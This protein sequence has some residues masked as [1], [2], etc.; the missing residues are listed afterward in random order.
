[1]VLDIGSGFLQAVK[2]KVYTSSIMR[3]GLY[4][5]CG[6]L[7]MIAFGALVDYAQQFIE[8]GY[9]LPIANSICSYIILMEIG[10]II[11]NVGKL[12][13]ELVPSKLKKYFTKLEG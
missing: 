12:N 11:E 8:L 4:H 7:F 6:S 5:K 2:N 1:M 13:P 10:S 3:E 9:N